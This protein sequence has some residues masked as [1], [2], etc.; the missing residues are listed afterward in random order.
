MSPAR[1]Q[2]PQHQRSASIP[3]KR[4]KSFRQPAL[5]FSPTAWAKLLFFRDKAET[6]IG[7]FAVTP[8][9]DLLYVEEFVTVRQDV[10]VASVSFDDEAVADFFDT[11]VDAGRKPEQFART[12]LHT[13]PGQS[14]EPSSI[15][16]ETFRRVFGRCQWAVMFILGRTGKTHARLR[17]NVGPGGQVAIPVHVDYS[18]PFGPSDYEAWEAEYK[19][20]IRTSAGGHLFGSC[21]GFELETGLADYSV[22]DD[23]LEELEAMDPAERRLILDELA[24]MGIPLL[25][26]I[27]FDVV[28]ESNIASQGFLEA[29]L[30][31]PK[32]DATADL[33]CR[34]NT[35]LVI[36]IIS[37]RFRRSMDVG[38]VVF[39]CVDS[40]DTRR[41][42]WEAVKDRVSFF[43]DGRMTAEVLRVLTACDA[44]SRQYYPTTLF[45]T[46]EAYTGSCTAKTTIYCANIAAGLMLAQF[47]KYLRRLPVD[48]DITLNLLAAELTCPAAR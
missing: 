43:A 27:D 44:P 13:H 32:V 34:I 17:F 10:T 2:E 40:I 36:R 19:A 42:I 21:Q 38:D 4:I 6:E 35:D 37:E 46:A 24:A 12:W 41:L 29:D 15:D 31:R 3:R 28:E 48:P 45:S 22:P 39:C 9:D 1:L 11:Q 8:A 16:E 30:G 33:C 7:G 23:W 5:R 26:L 18:R 47:T 14:P 25:Q 20:N